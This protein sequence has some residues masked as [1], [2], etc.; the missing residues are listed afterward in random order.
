VPAPLTT[1]GL[2]EARLKAGRL[3]PSKRAFL[4]QQLAR[5][6]AIAARNVGSK[7]PGVQQLAHIAQWVSDQWRGANAS[8]LQEPAPY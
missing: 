2:V 7:N 6:R 4:R 3:D 1:R 5:V 8:I